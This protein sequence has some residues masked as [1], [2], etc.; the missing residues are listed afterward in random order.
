MLRSTSHLLPEMHVA[1]TIWVPH[2][3]KHSSEPTAKVLLLEQTQIAPPVFGI[4]HLGLQSLVPDLQPLHL[5]FLEEQDERRRQD[6]AIE[7]ATS[8]L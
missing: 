2:V 8:E 6:D 1:M 5:R 7:A 4:S 3:K